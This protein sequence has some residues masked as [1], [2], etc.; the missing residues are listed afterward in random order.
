MT[1]WPN[2]RAPQLTTL[3]E[4]TTLLRG[5]EVQYATSGTEFERVPISYL[6]H[7]AGDA[8]KIAVTASAL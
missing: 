2:E 4:N 3:T 6:V 1:K 8:W 5:V 7:Q